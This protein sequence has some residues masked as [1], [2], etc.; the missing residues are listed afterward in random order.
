MTITTGFADAVGK[1]PLIEL[2]TLSKHLGCRI[3]GKAEFLNPGGSVKDR[4]A[5]YMIMDAE[6]HGKLLPGGTVVEGTAGNTGIGLTH[7]ANSRGYKTIIVMPNNQAQDKVFALQ[8]LGAEIKLVPPAPF[9]NPQ[10]YYHVAREL[11]ES[12]PGAFWANQFENTANAAAHYETTGPEIWHQCAGHIDG[13]ALAAGTGGTIGGLS[14]FLKEKN[15]KLTTLLIDPQGSGLYSYINSGTITAHG[16]S[17]TEGVGIMRLTDNFRQAKVDVAATI[18]D[19]AVIDMMVFLTK[20]EGLFLGSSS[21]L[22]VI[23]AI[24]LA[25]LLGRGTTI[26]TLL[27]DSGQRGISKFY[28]PQWLQTQNLLYRDRPLPELI[29]DL[30]QAT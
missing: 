16:T 18:A 19:Q 13:I 12:I 9:T 28:N 30:D 29:S 10:N 17:I 6:K 25:K 5:K 26:V 7:M 23:G 21:A 15:A 2:T 22:N 11:A 20:H 24:K 1:T 3:L 8:A 27:C 4:A 14:R